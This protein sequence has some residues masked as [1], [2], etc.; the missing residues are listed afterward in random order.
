MNDRKQT[1]TGHYATE[2]IGGVSFIHPTVSGTDYEGC[3]SEKKGN[4]KR[5]RSTW[6]AMWV[7]NPRRQLGRLELYR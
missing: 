1:S 3:G 4:L 7:S 2:N 6:S 5:A